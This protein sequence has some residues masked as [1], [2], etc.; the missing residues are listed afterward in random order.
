LKQLKILSATIMI[1]LFFFLAL[2][3]LIGVGTVWPQDRAKAALQQ[4]APRVAPDSAAL[5]APAVARPAKAESTNADTTRPAWKDWF[6]IEIDPLAA[7]IALI[8]LVFVA[9]FARKSRRAELRVE[10]EEQ[11]R[12]ELE[13][14]QRKLEEQLALLT[15]TR[16]FEEKRAEQKRT[17]KAKTAEERYRHAL[18]TEVCQ[19]HLAAPGLEEAP[20]NLLNTFVRL[21]IS[22]QYR[23]AEFP[24]LGDTERAQG[25]HENLSPEEVLTRAFQNYRR[26]LLLIIGDPG[27]GKT[28][29]LRY[30][31]ATCLQPEGY[32]QL[33][34]SPEVLPL[35]LPLRDVDSAKSLAE[36]LAVW[37]NKRDAGVA[38]PEF[39]AWLHER[40]TLVLLDGLDEIS[41]LEDRKKACAWIDDKCAGRKQ[42]R[43]VMTSRATGMRRTDNLALRTAHLHAE[44][45]DFSAEQK[46]EFLRKWFRA[47]HLEG[48]RPLKHETEADWRQR[49]LREAEKSAEEVIAYLEQPENRSLRELAGIPMLLQLI[50][51][52]WKQYQ[53]K[54][55]SRTKLYD[56]ALDYLL[57]Y[58]DDQRGYAPLL[59]ADKARRVLSPAALWMQEELNAEE[60]TKDKMHG[61]LQPIIEPINNTLQAEE[62]CANLRDR[63]GVMADYGKSE[64]IFRHKSFREYFAG[65]QLVTN[66]NE[67]DRLARLVKTFGD[68]AWAEPLRYFMSKADGKAFSAFM[69]ALFDSPVSREFN[70]SQQDL[71]E[72]LVRE[73]PEKQSE[74]LL[75][76]LRDQK[77]TANQQ[78]YALDCL[79]IIGGETVRKQLEIFAG[80]GQG[81]AKTLAYAREIA[82][83]LAA[84]SVSAVRPA[85][86]PQLFAELPASF[87]NEVEYNAEYILI[88]GGTIESSAT[89]QIEKVPD[90]YF[91]KYPVTNK[92]YRR[93]I[94]YLMG[95]E[96]EIGKLV[97]AKVFAEKFLEFVSTDK[98]YTDYFGLRPKGHTAVGRDA[99]TWSEKLKSEFDEDRKFNGEEQ[100]V[101]GVSWYA[102][103]AY[104]FWLS[105]CENGHVETFRRNVSTP[106]IST[107]NVSTPD[108]S[109]IYRLPHETEWQRA[110]AGRRED[111]APRKYPWPKEKGEPNDKLANYG[112]NVGQT[113]PVGR[114]PEGATPE[115]LMD[116]AGNV[117]EWQEN[118]DAKDK[119]ARALR[120]GSWSYDSVYLPSAIRSRYIPVN[121]LYIVGFRVV[122]AQSFFGTL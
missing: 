54:P 106:D 89:K 18:E 67:K 73:A 96:T 77:K 33:G 99:K 45:R 24:Q 92:Q 102:A 22:E 70:Q 50:A 44:V 104:C 19:I 98:A 91:A 16:D 4:P 112:G 66:Y 107:R 29:L 53:T 5:N 56:I 83:S 28:T 39:D 6:A 25:L 2:W 64:Y 122:R 101:V 8:S 59:K 26:K 32:K 90:I 7:L 72:G 30:Y 71:L 118:W 15:A 94:R 43:F 121:R 74:A 119:N 51:L 63:A 68:N 27:S 48:S 35:Y 108:V 49:Q 34:F 93:F 116:M 61:Y 79:K 3:W 46:R 10:R 57:E 23:S 80:A 1:R 62:L 52:I 81:K 78:R 21:N 55:E 13:D 11:K 40:E 113:T 47:A 76:C 85:I 69:A 103:R 38:A 65:M 36:N 111:G 100:P 86:K 31:A 37:A 115:G 17:Q 114:Y 84:P 12:T 95:E 87:R 14:R 109:T 42:A 41:K 105:L 88:R 110:A 75:A 20:V 97:S 60:V 117:W 82:A 9:Y 120:G 58:R